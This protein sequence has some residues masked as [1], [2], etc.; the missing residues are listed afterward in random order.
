M[1]REV[2]EAIVQGLKETGIDFVSY[3][4]ESWLHDVYD[5]VLE[6]PHFEVVLGANEGECVGIVSGAWLGGRKPVTIFENSGLRVAAETLARL[7]IG[8]GIPAFMIMPYRGDF[9]DKDWWAIPSGDTLLPMLEALQVH[10]KVVE[11]EEDIIPT[12]QGAW[13]V[14]H[15]SKKP[16]AVII[17][18]RLAQ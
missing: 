15:V 14:L 16:V 2:T 6:D 9:G 1:R 10:Y 18:G 12:I 4:P 17:G 3:L 5:A 13:E 11:R 8:H 7:G